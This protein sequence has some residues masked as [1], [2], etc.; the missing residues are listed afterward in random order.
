VIASEVVS[1]PA[2]RKVLMLWR[3]SSSVRR[4]SGGRSV[5]VLD[6]TA[7]T[8]RHA[9]ARREAGEKAYACRRGDH[10]RRVHGQ[11]SLLRRF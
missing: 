8:F 4:W 11:T 2:K 10:A 6:L 3:M 5:A 1:E 9:E 7:R